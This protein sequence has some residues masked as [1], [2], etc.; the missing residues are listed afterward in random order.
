VGPECDAGPADPCDTIVC[1]A[2]QECLDGRCRATDPCSDVV[3]GTPGEVCDPRDGL[4]HA[5]GADDDGDGHTIAEGDCDD[6]D[7]GTYP[8]ATE[9]CDGRDND[10]DLDVDEGFAD[11]DG[12]GFDV[13]G[14]GDASQADCDD[15]SDRRHPGRS[16]ACDGLDNDCDGDVDEGL[17][18]RSCTT[19]CAT[20][21]ERCEGGEWVCSA[22]TECDCTP[23]GTVD[24]E[25]CGYCGDRSRT[26]QSDLTWSSWSA[27]SGEG[28]CPA[29]TDESR[30]CGDC[31]LGTQ[32]RTCS[33]RC[34]WGSWST[35]VGGGEC[36][37][38]D[39]ETRPCG[40]CDEGTERR[41]CTASCTWG[42]WGSCTGTGCVPGTEQGEAC[43]NC[44]W[45]THERTCDGSCSWPAWSACTV[46]GPDGTCLSCSVALGP[47]S[48]GPYL[49][50]G[51]HGGTTGRWSSGDGTIWLGVSTTART[52]TFTWLGRYWTETCGVQTGFLHHGQ[53]RVD[54]VVVG[55]YAIGTTSSTVSSFPISAA[56]AADRWLEIVVE[57]DHL[58]R[59]VDCSGT[60]DTRWLGT[61]VYDVDA[62]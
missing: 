17:S 4:C 41:T 24:E 23:P 42:S 45:G 21:E 36:E 54:G 59:P 26:C 58:F 1:A 13:C 44:G 34:T 11:A 19:V 5:G 35:C 18:P 32:S 12:D 22:P 38:G 43:G 55:S 29:G 8:G 7:D 37:A 60:S 10:C 33:T 14:F 31:S 61:M 40:A 27:C 48:D 53:V 50:T 39:A 46:G 15:S 2:G 49:G 47:S 57:P 52:L 25:G 9:A 16:E 51:W 56:A 62:C 6:G 20:G 28:V 30:S 3:C